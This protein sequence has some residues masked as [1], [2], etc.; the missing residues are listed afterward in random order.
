MQ[1]EF[2]PVPARIRKSHTAEH[3][4][5]VWGS[6]RGDRAAHKASCPRWLYMGST[7]STGALEDRCLGQ[8]TGRAGEH[9][10][11]AQSA[12]QECVQESTKEC[13]WQSVCRCLTL[14]AVPASRLWGKERLQGA[15]NP[16][17][18][19]CPTSGSLHVTAYFPHASPLP[20]RREKLRVRL[21]PSQSP[22]SSLMIPT[23]VFQVV[24]LT[25]STL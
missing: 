15:R 23:L 24:Q 12:M 22:G 20:D 13:L 25:S 1:G 9:G 19:P 21:M 16:K 2:L 6:R 14:G 4:H 11:A 3:R 10:H 8:G 7:A 18:S 17:A 5:W